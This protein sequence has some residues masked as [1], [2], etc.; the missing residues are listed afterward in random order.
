MGWGEAK[1]REGRKRGLIAESPLWDFIAISRICEVLEHKHWMNCVWLNFKSYSLQYPPEV[2]CLPAVTA[3]RAVMCL[4]SGA[5]S[6]S[7]P[8]SLQIRTFKAEECAPTCSYQLLP[9]LHAGWEGSA[10]CVAPLQSK[11]EPSKLQCILAYKERTCVQNLAPV[12][13]VPH[14]CRASAPNWTVVVIMCIKSWRKINVCAH[15]A[16]F[17]FLREERWPSARQGWGENHVRGE[18]KNFMSQD[19]RG[20]T[21]HRQLAAW[22]EVNSFDLISRP[23]PIK[24][25]FT[26][27][28]DGDQ[29]QR[30]TWDAATSKCVTF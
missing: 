12:A 18:N 2:Q 5:T 23:N 29:N 8:S 4:Y 26:I 11:S 17:F 19:S 22:T 20:L 7:S 15:M 21:V 14:D 3:W 1:E 9:A 13:F 24:L 30:L 25:Q 28:H 6:P 16:F 10:Y 27:V